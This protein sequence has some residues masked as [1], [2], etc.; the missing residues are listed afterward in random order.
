MTATS[1]ITAKTPSADISAREDEL[2]NRLVASA[3]GLPRICAVKKCR[4][5]KRCFGPDLVC[6]RHHHGLA[7]ARFKGALKKL[8]WPSRG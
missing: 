1:N 6:L 3:A 8:G 5:A 2:A 7:R 4:R